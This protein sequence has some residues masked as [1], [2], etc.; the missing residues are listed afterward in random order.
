MDSK[1]YL[2][3]FGHWSDADISMGRRMHPVAVVAMDLL[4]SHP[5]VAGVENG[6]DTK[7]RSKLRLQRP[8]ELVDRTFKI[9]QLWYERMLNLSPVGLPPPSKFVEYRGHKALLEREMLYPR[10]TREEP[11]TSHESNN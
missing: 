9:A 4:R 10:T 5:N 11:T 7:G 2:D 3:N 8:E 1:E 6:E